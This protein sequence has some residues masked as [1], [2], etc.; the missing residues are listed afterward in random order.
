MTRE[1]RWSDRA[2]VACLLGAMVGWF[3]MF[4]PWTRD[5]VPF[6]AVMPCAAVSLA[7]V[8][9]IVTQGWPGRWGLTWPNVGLGA[10]SAL[11]LWG[12][13]WVGNAVSRLILPFAGRQV[14]TIY[15]LRDGNSTVV[16]GVLLA[17]VIGPTEELF[18]RGFLQHRLMSTR[19]PWTGLALTT[20]TYTLVHLWSGN[21]M[22]T[23]AAGVAGTLWG[24]LYCWRGSLVACIVSHSLWD[25]T[26][27]LLLPIN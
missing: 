22:L 10:V 21:V 3:F 26:V 4:S 2:V 7:A 11:A 6:W 15:A 14:S 23:G 5:T 19:G 12:V 17:C 16:L 13:F 9:G 25:V 8:A 24:L 27:F 1:E 20:A 18:W